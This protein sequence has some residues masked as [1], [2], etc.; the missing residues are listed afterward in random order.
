MCGRYVLLRPDLRELMKKLHLEELY[1]LSVVAESRFNIAP[2]QSVP[3]LRAD[4][5]GSPELMSLSWGWHA[6]SNETPGRSVFVLNARSES[7]LRRPAFQTAYRE[8][9]CVLP[10]SGFYE[11]KRDTKPAQPYYIQF[12]NGE[13]FF[14]AGLWQPGAGTDDACVVVTAPANTLMRPIHDRMPVMLT[15]EGALER[16]DRRNENTNTLNPLLSGARAERM[17]LR[18]V[19]HFVNN[20]KNEGEACLQA[21]LLG[22]S[23]GSEQLGFE[24]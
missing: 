2:S 14:L 5:T 10:A 20:A 9:R 23:P 19:S 13:P 8:R 22:E 16:L 7:L 4:R 11:W 17:A 15:A 3:A 1:N 24:F 6:P 21:P 18:P 12:Q